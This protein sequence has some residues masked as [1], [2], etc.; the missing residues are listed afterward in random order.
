MGNDVAGPPGSLSGVRQ[1]WSRSERRVPRV[2]LQ[3][4][5]SFLTTEAAGGVLLMVATAVA[6]VWANSPWDASYDRLWHTELTVGLGRWHLSYDLGRWVSDGLMTVF[7][8]VVGLEIKREVFT[9]ELR[10]PRAAAVPVLAALGGM[11]VPA[12]LFAAIAAGGDGSRG[13]GIPMATDIAFALGIL[14]LVARSA[15][16]GLKPFLL[17]LAIVDDIGAILVIAIFYSGGV[18]AEPLL[19][20]AAA[21]AAVVLLQR[22]HIRAAA[23]YVVLGLVVWVA[24]AESGIHPTIAGVVLGL[25]TPAVPFQRP[26][27]VSREAHRVADETVDDPSPPDVDAPY[28]LYLAGLSREAVSPLARVESLLHPWVSFVIV[29]LFALAN[30]GV[31]L[32]AGALADAAT[33]S[34]ALGILVGLVVGK[35]LGIALATAIA[36]RSGLGPMPAGAGWR[37]VIGVGAVAGVGFTISLLITDLAF[38]GSPLLDAAKAGILAASVLAGILGAVVLGAGRRARPSNPAE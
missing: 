31:D 1:P 27:T 20:A 14:T 22:I 12:L 19:I 3:P 2:V 34:L 8:L 30:A 33:S 26:K 38:E 23:V 18:S 11:V 37:D 13:W 17:T 4:L 24:T 32:S 6:L 28:W 15:P 10:A 36:V 21:C 29:P 25:L 35:P 7:F 9:G 16:P 5:Q